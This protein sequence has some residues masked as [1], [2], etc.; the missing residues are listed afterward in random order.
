MHQDQTIVLNLI[1]LDVPF[2]LEYRQSLILLLL[3]LAFLRQLLCLLSVLGCAPDEFF[4][5]GEHLGDGVP[6]AASS[7][8]VLILVHAVAATLEALVG[9][10]ASTKHVVASIAE[11]HRS[12]APSKAIVWRAFRT[13]WVHAVLEV[14]VVVHALHHATM[15][16]S[17]WIVF[18]ETLFVPHHVTHQLT[19][20]SFLLLYTRLFHRC[21]IWP[22]DHHL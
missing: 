6:S 4:G 11:T 14:T 3:L 7:T 12:I 18:H 20:D 5:P 16:H 2:S 13:E 9:S 19:F 8:L 1:K 10:L 22:V 21:D 17:H 15:L